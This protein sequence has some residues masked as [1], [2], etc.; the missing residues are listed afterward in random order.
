MATKV[1]LRANPKYCQ[2]FVDLFCKNNKDDTLEKKEEASSVRSRDGSYDI[3][4]LENKGGKYEY[5][6]LGGSSSQTLNH[7]Y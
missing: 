4:I 5:K 6:G 3:Q 2:P 1:P 7:S